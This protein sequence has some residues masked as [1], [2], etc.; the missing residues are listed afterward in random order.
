MPTKAPRRLRSLG[1]S[2]GLWLLALLVLAGVFGLYLQP[3][4]AFTLANRLWSCF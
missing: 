3:G 1:R 4:L 2:L